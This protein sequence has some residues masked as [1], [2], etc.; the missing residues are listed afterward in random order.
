[1][2]I[3]LTLPLTITLVSHLNTP[4]QLQT[5]LNHPS[6][7]YVKIDQQL[8]RKQFVAP[9]RISILALLPDSHKTV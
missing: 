8:R 4:E 2:L 1:M 9:G 7:N 3:I 5:P 6:A